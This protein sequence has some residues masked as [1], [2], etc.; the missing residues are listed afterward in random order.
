MKP[1]EP[2]TSAPSPSFPF[3]RLRRY[4]TSPTLRALVREHHVAVTDLIQ[5]LF[6][7]QQRTTPYEIPSMPGV[8]QYALEHLEEV[9]GAWMC[10]GI[11]S[12]LLF[13]VPHHKDA[14]AHEAYDVDG[15]VQQAIRYLKHTFPSLYVIADTCVCA[16]TDHGHCGWISPHTGALENDHS[17]NMHVQT[18][19]SQAQAGADCIAPS[20]MLDGVVGAI[21]HGLDC[22]GFPT[23]P[24]MAYAV[25]FASAY[26]G[27]FRDAAD[28]APQFGDR[29]T[30][31]MDPANRREALREAQADVEQGADFLMVKPAL[32]YLDIVH[33]LRQTFLL[34]IVAYH[35]SGEYSMIKAGAQCGWIDERTVVLETLLGMRR[36]GADLIITYHAYAVAQWLQSENAQWP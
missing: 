31:Q 24:I 29:R 17:L 32:A 1:H 7:C 16:Y 6:V 23:V 21:R 4:R 9:V 18:A 5:P 2:L 28:S 3:A 30:Y 20:S 8:Y 22:A 15:V 25:K 13:G 33:A 12:V 27:P 10:A 26:Y 14:H 11:R 34:P 35:V 36:A 19:V